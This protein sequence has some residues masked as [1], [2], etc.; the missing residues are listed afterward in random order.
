MHVAVTYTVKLQHTATKNQHSYKEQI[1]TSATKSIHSFWIQTKNEHRET[2]SV[3]T[4]ITEMNCTYRKSRLTRFGLVSSTFLKIALAWGGKNVVLCNGCPGL[5]S[6][7]VS[8]VREK[9]NL[10]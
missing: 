2:Y 1:R 10:I 3:Y 8:M 5:L 6:F 7:T 9:G 4:F